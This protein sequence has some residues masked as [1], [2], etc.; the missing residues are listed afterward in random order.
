MT[1]VFIMYIM[2]ILLLLINPPFTGGFSAIGGSAP[3]GQARLFLYMDEILMTQDSVDQLKKELEHL[4]KEVMPSIITKIEEAQKLGDL[5]ENAEYHSAKDDQGMA[6]GR[7][8]EIEAILQQVRVIEAASGKT[9]TI[10]SKITLVDLDTM[11]EKDVQ[12]VDQVQSNPLEGK[13]SNESPMGKVLIG[14][15]EGDE[16]IVE[17][18]SAMKKYK[19]IKV[20]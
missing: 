20:G 14:Q 9:I 3:G 10:G 11:N 13:I 8:R 19:I 1:L 4:K 18:P 16:V 12:V 15:T 2:Y 6:A 5:S 7:I 17:L